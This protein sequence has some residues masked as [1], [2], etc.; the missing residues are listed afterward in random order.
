MSEFC[1][2]AAALSGL[3][4]ADFSRYQHHPVDNIVDNRVDQAPLQRPAWNTGPPGEIS[5]KNLLHQ[6]VIEH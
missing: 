6:L 4:D 3:S 5:N 1:I 2:S